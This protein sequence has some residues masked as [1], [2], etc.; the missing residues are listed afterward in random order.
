MTMTL[1]IGGTTHAVSTQHVHLPAAAAEV[2]GALED[3]MGTYDDKVAKLLKQVKPTVTERGDSD[4]GTLKLDYAF[5]S[6]AD[7]KYVAKSL[8]GDYDA[9]DE[10]TGESLDTSD[11]RNL[12]MRA[13]H[14]HLLV[15]VD[16]TRTADQKTPAKAQSLVTALQNG[17]ASLPVS[18]ATKRA[19]ANK[20]T[21]TSLTHPRDG[22]L[23]VM[24][25]LPKAA[26]ATA[27]AADLKAHHADVRKVF[28]SVAGMDVST[29]SPKADN[30][31]L[32]VHLAWKAK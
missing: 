12:S 24:Y 3:Q 2:R 7:A 25:M 20:P 14:N 6:A 26:D 29:I 19:L 23:D 8:N 1:R 5:K 11:F 4:K 15:S 18:D 28:S 30:Q 21:V 27:A 31:F 9:I 22:T 17:A 10:N 32:T 16:W 13:Q